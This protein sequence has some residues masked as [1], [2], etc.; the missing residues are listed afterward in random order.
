[1]DVNLTN[2]S[3]TVVYSTWIIDDSLRF[4]TIPQTGINQPTALDIKLFEFLSSN[5]ASQS[6]SLENFFGIGNYSYEIEA[7]GLALVDV[8]GNTFNKVGRDLLR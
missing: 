3:G 8:S 1:M 6:T 2:F 4:I 5:I 7:D